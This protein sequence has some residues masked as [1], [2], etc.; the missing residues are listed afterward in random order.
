MGVALVD[1]DLAMPNAWQSV[2]T[3]STNAPKNGPW[4]APG[5]TRGA[6]APAARCYAPPIHAAPRSSRL[7]GRSRSRRCRGRCP[8]RSARCHQHRHACSE[9]RSAERFRSARVLLDHLVCCWSK[10]ARL[11]L[12]WKAVGRTGSSGAPAPAAHHTT[13][14]RRCSSCSPA[15]APP[16]PAEPCGRYRD[17]TR[18]AMRSGPGSPAHKTPRSSM[19]YS[20]LGQSSDARVQC[21]CL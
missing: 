10:G 9:L 16:P 2:M 6:P 3:Q 20:I 17:R 21:R 18:A 11:G 15:P 1:P 12:E 8:P 19:L 4:L 7:A 14:L 5:G 13:P